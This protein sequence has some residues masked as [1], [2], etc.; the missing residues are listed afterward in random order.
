M[1]YHA[2]EASLYEI[3]LS[4]QQQQ[5]INSGPQFQRAD[6]L[7]ACLQATKSLWDAFFTIPTRNFFNFSIMTC[8]NLSISMIILQLLCTFEHPE[9]NLT[10][11]REVMDFNK[12][13]DRLTACF[14]KVQTE[15]GCEDMDLFG[16]M[17]KKLGYM[18]DYVEARSAD[19]YRD[20]V[21]EPRGNQ[22]PQNTNAGEFTDF[23]DDAWL[24]DIFGPWDFQSSLG[25]P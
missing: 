25:M 9:W 17:A 10:R 18:R 7:Y 6:A 4:K 16:R 3:G 14:N 21:P 20:Q 19:Q 2:T 15:P 24:K 12:L 23:L 13:I 8:S 11:V 1:Y 5:I 22:A